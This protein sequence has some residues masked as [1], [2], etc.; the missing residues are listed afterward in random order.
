MASAADDE[1]NRRNAQRSTG[2]R[3]DQGKARARLNA[4][5]HGKTAR[6]DLPQEDSK[7]LKERT[8]QW[9]SDM[10]PRN[11]GEHDLVCQAARLSWEIERAE[12]IETAHLARQVS[13]ALTQTEQASARRR[14]KVRELGRKLLPI[15]GSGTKSSRRA[16]WHDDPAVLVCKPEETAEGCGW[17]LEQWAKYRSLLD[18]RSYWGTPEMLR[19]IRLQ[20]KQSI[21]AVYDPALNSILLAWEM[22][23]PNVIDAFWSAC[24]DQ[25]PS[26]DLALNR[27][28][29][30]H[31]IAPRPHNQTG[32]EAV[33]YVVVD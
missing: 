30:W 15:A 23:V 10:Q 3:T 2:P 18:R 8:Q 27:E 9:L 14:K 12:R 22:L 16:S 33:I 1:A 26:V 19:F 6:T 29:Q 31:E 4:L 32:A 24:K 5:K 17:L 11:A 21:E 7:E 25:L 28:L 13:A 20:G